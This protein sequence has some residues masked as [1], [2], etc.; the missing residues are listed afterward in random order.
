MNLNE[1]Y[2]KYVYA[3]GLDIGTSSVGYSI[4][5]LDVNK[6]YVYPRKFKALGIFD[7]S[8]SSNPRCRF[9]NRNRRKITRR[10]TVSK[11]KAIEIWSPII[12]VIMQ[13]V[14]Q[15]IQIILS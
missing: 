8:E 4:T 11:Q 3:I 2:T 5:S 9:G 14:L 10:R 15:I 12:C 6:N 13:L 1:N 7:F